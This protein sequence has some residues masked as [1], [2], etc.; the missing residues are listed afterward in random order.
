MRGLA[1]LL[2]AAAAPA[3]LFTV[4]AEH[5]LVEGIASDGRTIWVSSVL[6]RAIVAHRPGGDRTI[7]LPKGVAHP[8]GLAWDAQRRW[9]W[10]ATDC[11]ALPGIAHCESGAL[12]AIDPR[13]MLR[14]SFRPDIPLHSGDVSVGGGSVF[15]S[16]SQNGAVYR[17]PP[18]GK[19]LET[20]VAPGI[21]KSAQGSAL[22]PSGRRLIVADYGRGLFAI[23]L[24]TRQRTPLLE[25]GKPLRGLDGLARVGDSYFA[26]YNASSPARL[27]R[28]R[29]QGDAVVE[30]TAIDAALP[31]PT[32]L[33][34]YRGMLL[35][36]A[37]AGWE[38]AAKSEAGKRAPAPIVSVPL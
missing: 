16:D 4:P 1:A 37:S 14:A 15:V 31:D 7:R 10:I 34:A 27:I 32:Q 13:G 2:L 6:D 25:E 24:A 9:L 5:R 11:P 18:A 38:D 29:L 8:L 26:I 3:T 17:L 19:A 21:G 23:D 28:F 33:V 20:L 22:D 30:G 35:V 36:V 12:V